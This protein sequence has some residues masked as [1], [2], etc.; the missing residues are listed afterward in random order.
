MEAELQPQ[1]V[2]VCFTFPIAQT[3]RS[4]SLTKHG[5]ILFVTH[6]HLQL[7]RIGLLLPHRPMA[8]H[9]SALPARD[10]ELLS[11]SE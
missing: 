1:V 2:W 8:V 10:A 3:P 6:A 9:A 4:S 11:V 7:I 5:E